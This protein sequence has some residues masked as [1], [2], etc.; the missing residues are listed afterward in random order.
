MKCTGTN[1]F[2]GQKGNL[3]FL[4]VKKQYASPVDFLHVQ[5][6]KFILDTDRK[7]AGCQSTPTALPQFHQ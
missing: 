1:V 6:Q 5:V 3:S 2:V 7:Y 4:P